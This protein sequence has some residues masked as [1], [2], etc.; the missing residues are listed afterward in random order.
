MPLPTQDQCH[1]PLLEHS[2]ESGEP[3]H[4]LE[5]AE[6]IADT[7]ALT[8]QEREER[9]PVKGTPRYVDRTNWA[10][11]LLKRAGLMDVRG[12]SKYQINEAGQQELAANSGI[13]T[14]PYLENLAEQLAAKNNLGVSSVL[15]PPAVRVESESSPW[16][17][18]HQAWQSLNRQLAEDLLESIKEVPSIRFERLVLDLLNKMG[19]GE[20]EHTGQS[21]DGGIDGIIHQ[22]ALGLEKVY[23]Q[24][25]RYS[26]GSIGEP[27]I[28]NF[29]GS[30]IA[31][32]ATKGVF[33]TTSGFSATAQQTAA[34]VS[35]RNETIRLV[36][37]HELAQLMIRHG[38]G[39]VTEYTYEIKKLDENYFAEEI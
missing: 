17:D 39:V 1:L 6:H 12:K 34:N 8:D 3:M 22:D 19:Y 29:A 2:A 5:L 37:G 14:K 20:P 18:A 38:V 23:V 25:K 24:A 11:S 33:I 31:R 27:E 36:A 35:Q 10:L 32:G 16:E 4:R 9:T 28:R 7:F 13:I 30:M 21:G 15:V 26:S